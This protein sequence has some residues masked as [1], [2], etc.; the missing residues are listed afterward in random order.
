MLPFWLNMTLHYLPAVAGIVIPGTYALI[1][2]RRHPRLSL[3]VLGVLSISV[4]SNVLWFYF[5]PN[6]P[7]SGMVFSTMI[8]Y[9]YSLTSL[10]VWGLLFFAVF[11]AFYEGR[12]S[13]HSAG[14]TH[15]DQ[16]NDPT[17][18]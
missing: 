7:S 2:W 14:D 12:R 10:L 3:L 16:Q 6:S 11:F 18:R 15:D 13:A 5:C 8:F 17:K 4:L 1:R 9:L